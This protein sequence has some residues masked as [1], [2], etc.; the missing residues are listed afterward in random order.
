MRRIACCSAI[1][2]LLLWVGPVSFVQGEGGALLALLG[3]PPSA[4]SANDLFGEDEAVVLQPGTPIEFRLRNGRTVRG[5]YLGRSV[6]DSTE[7]APRFAAA[8]PGPLALGETL[9]VTL[10]DGREWIAPFEGY[11]ELSLLMR[12]A[13]GQRVRVPFEFARTIAHAD[14]QRVEP[15]Q[16]TRA[17]RSGAL[18]SAEVLLL[19]GADPVG[20]EEE[21]RASALHIPAQDIRSTIV[22]TEGG[23]VA[24]AAILLGVVGGLVLLAVLVSRS[25][26]PSCVLSALDNVPLLGFRPIDRPFDHSRGLFVGDSLVW[27]GELASVSGGELAPVAIRASSAA[28]REMGR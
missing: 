7:Y 13:D 20:T 14:G 9:H 18:P 28:P 17:F 3:A 10:H 5:L 1:L 2:L 27:T 23:D 8:P 16:L 24:T 15:K 6:L 11:G 4:H 19:E 22:R 21:R 12:A 25:S 26:E